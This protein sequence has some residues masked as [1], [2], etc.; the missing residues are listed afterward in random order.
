MEIERRNIEVEAANGNRSF[1]SGDP[2]FT[3]EVE[4]VDPP[5][6]EAAALR[7]ELASERDAR[8]R[9]AA[10]YE[11]YR[12]RTKRDSAK[13]ADD[14][15]RELLERMLSIADDLDLALA[16][17][18]GSAGVV[19]EGVRLIHRRFNDLLDTTGVAA[20]ESKGKVFDPEIHEA[21]DVASGTENEPGTVHEEIRR[22]YF[23]NDRLL[24][25]ALVVVAQ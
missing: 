6:S 15:K 25:P 16:N 13:A 19:A 12:R 23:W 2:V 1:R 3:D 22:G 18:D 9:L 7:E 24:R 17:L 5:E 8:L 10:E 11:N 20:F 4:A 14:G 21:F